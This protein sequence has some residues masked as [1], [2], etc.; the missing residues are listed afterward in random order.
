M[1]SQAAYILN[2]L[3]AHVFSKSR[4]F[5]VHAAGED[6]IL[7]DQ[8]AIAVAQ[9]VETILL[10]EPAAPDPQHVHMGRS[11]VPDQALQVGI[12]DAGGERI[13]RDPVCTLDEDWDA[14][15]DEGERLAP[16]VRFTTQLQGAQP[17]LVTAV[18]QNGFLRIRGNF[19]FVECLFPEA[20]RPPELRID[21]LRLQIAD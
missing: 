7:P 9:V 5:R 1:L 8:D 12:A 16:L 14:V 19:H 17:D 4:I 3:H 10:V 21:D 11:R 6:E 15:D 13:G 18:V 2:R 20:I